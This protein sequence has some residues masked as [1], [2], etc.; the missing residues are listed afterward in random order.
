MSCH[1]F[2]E[3]L[4]KSEPCQQQVGNRSTRLQE[5][6][7]NRNNVTQEGWLWEGIK[8]QGLLSQ[9]GDS[10]S[11]V[12]R[13]RAG[14]A[15]LSTRCCG[16]PQHPRHPAATVHCFGWVRYQTGIISGQRGNRWLLQNT[17]VNH[18]AAHTSHCHDTQS[19]AADT[20]SKEFITR[21]KKKLVHFPPPFSFQI[22]FSGQRNEKELSH[23]IQQMIHKSNF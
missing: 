6:F 12:F 1:V 9:R 5:V 21:A 8:S 15:S 13:W 11:A 18:A 2:K 19:P 4:V 3:T 16:S 7:C 17:N 14:A 20:F 23:Q 22:E 10:S